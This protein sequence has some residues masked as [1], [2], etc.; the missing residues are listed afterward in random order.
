MSSFAPPRRR[1]PHRAGPDARDE[2]RMARVNAEL[3]RLA[4]Q[5]DELRLAREDLLLGA[6]DVD[7]H[8]DC[9]DL[10]RPVFQLLRLRNGVFDGPDH[11]ERLFGQVVVLTVEN[12]L[13]A[14]HRVLRA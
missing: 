10:L 5:H 12:R 7:V 8:G 9:H 2:R 3:A 11:V 4:R 6:D 13:E 1:D 14:S